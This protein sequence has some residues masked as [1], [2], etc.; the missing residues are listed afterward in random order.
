MDMYIA[1][2]IFIVIIVGGILYDAYMMG[3]NMA[4]KSMNDKAIR[5]MSKQKEIEDAQLKEAL[6]GAT[7]RADA[8]KR[9]QS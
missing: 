2:G 5:L 8:V 1:L 4:T 7:S 3:K 6:N 9:M